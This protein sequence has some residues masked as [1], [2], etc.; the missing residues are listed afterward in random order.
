MLYP[1]NGDCTVAIDSVT[2]PPY[3][4]SVKLRLSTDTARIV[5]RVYG[6]VGR[7]SVRPSLRLSPIDSS[8]GRR[9]VCC[10][11]PH[12]PK[13]G[14][15]IDNRRAPAFNSNGARRARHSARQQMRAVLCWQPRY[16][17]EHRLFWFVVKSGIH[18]TADS[19]FNP[20]NTL[21]QPLLEPFKTCLKIQHDTTMHKILLAKLSKH[22]PLPTYLF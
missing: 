6:T 10:W 4:Y 20:E 7:Q 12:G 1:Q 5:C 2:S 3:V 17:A 13:I 21:A 19:T 22:V 11:A 14:L 15:S 9:W 8:N 16:E 18:A